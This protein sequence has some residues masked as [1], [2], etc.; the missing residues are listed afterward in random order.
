M[1]TESINRPIMFITIL[2]M[3]II[4]VTLN[5]VGRDRVSVVTDQQIKKNRKAKVI[6]SI[7]N[8]TILFILLLTTHLYMYM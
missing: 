3:K 8:N 7:R 4:V 6:K 2:L 5:D 1:T